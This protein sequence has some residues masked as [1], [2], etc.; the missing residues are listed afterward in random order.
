M[1]T[2]RY[3]IKRNDKISESNVATEDYS[4][5]RERTILTL[6]KNK[7]EKDTIIWLKTIASPYQLA[8]VMLIVEDKDGDVVSLA[9][10]N[11]MKAPTHLIELNKIFP[12]GVK[13][14]VKQPYLKI[15]YSGTLSLINDNPQNIIFITQEMDTRSIKNTSDL[16]ELE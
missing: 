1:M 14:G 9:L 7:I 11:Q 16:D 8:S 3:I 12:K 6:K 4:N 13:L 15:Q 2:N 5:F 10:Y